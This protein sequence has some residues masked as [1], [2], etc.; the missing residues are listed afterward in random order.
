VLTLVKLVQSIVK[1][2]HSDG[3]PGQVAMGLALGSIVGLTPLM[4]LHNAVLLGLIIILNVS[5]P[6][7]MLGIAL[8]TPF[9]F[10][11]DPLFDAVGRRLLMDTPA[12]EPLWT[13]LW[14]T[15][16]VPLTNFNNTVVLGSVVV[17]LAL[18]LPVLVGARWGVARYRATVAERIRRSRWYRAVTASKAYNVYR[19][20]W[21]EP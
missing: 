1:A 19:M 15:P 9:G 11:L 20:F 13:S 3:T 5:F 8:F 2:L 4:N 17:S 16:V 21:P 14:N 7:A 12:L 6:G 10:L 18:F